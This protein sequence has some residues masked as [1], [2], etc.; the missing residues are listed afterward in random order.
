MW[1]APSHPEM[2]GASAATR[3]RASVKTRT[4][5]GARRGFPHC[6]VG[7]S[8]VGQMT[9][10]PGRGAPPFT[11]PTYLDSLALAAVV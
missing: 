8:W 5:A 1:W 3:M 2:R 4:G 9:E 10:I 7:G 6:V 11:A